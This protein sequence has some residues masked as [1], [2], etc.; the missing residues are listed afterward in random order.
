MVKNFATY[1]LLTV[2][3]KSTAGANIGTPLSYA[4]TDKANVSVTVAGNTAAQT[5]IIDG[6]VAATATGTYVTIDSTP[7]ATAG[8][9]NVGITA[10]YTFIRAR[11]A[12]VLSTATTVSASIATQGEAC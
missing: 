10:P 4:R 2:A 7:S 8:S 5:V 11:V 6:T 3:A 12:T 9:Y 1:N